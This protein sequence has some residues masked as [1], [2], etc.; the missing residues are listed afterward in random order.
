MLEGLWTAT[1]ASD[2]SAF[3]E[4]SISEGS[5]IFV[6]NNNMI[7]GGD[8]YYYYKGTYEYIN[9]AKFKGIL[10]VTRYIANTGFT[11][12]KSSVFGN[13]NEFDLEFVADIKDNV[14]LGTGSVMQYKNA[15]F[16]ARL[17]KRAELPQPLQSSEV[18]V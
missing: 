9:E 16:A 1:Y 2:V 18:A 4:G 14:I 3:N 6:F 5:G 13:L 8:V 10:H 17:V 11:G 15:H 7:L 12:N